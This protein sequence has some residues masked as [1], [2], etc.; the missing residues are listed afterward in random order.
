MKQDLS[1]TYFASETGVLTQS[2]TG[3]TCGSKIWQ[4]FLVTYLHKQED[5]LWGYTISNKI[6][7]KL[8]LEV[9]CLQLLAAGL[10]LELVVLTQEV[11]TE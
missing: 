4:L 5:L 1:F 6:A 10:V 9:F 2:I 3:S 11:V 7:L 8:T